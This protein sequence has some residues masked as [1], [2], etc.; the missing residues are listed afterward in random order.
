MKNKNGLN[1]FFALIAFPLGLILMKHINFK[2]LTLKEPAIDTLYIII[3]VLSI[4]FTFK[5]PKQ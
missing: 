4:Y 1:I 5:N 2:T 3:F